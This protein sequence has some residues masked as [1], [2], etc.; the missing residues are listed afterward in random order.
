VVV[1]GIDRATP[2]RAGVDRQ[3]I[4]AFLDAGTQL[5]Q[6]GGQGRDPVRLFVADVGDVA[7]RGRPVREAGHGRECHHGVTD[8]VHVHVDATEPA[9]A[10]DDQTVRAVRNLAAHLFEEFDEPDVALETAARMGRGEAAD[11]DRTAGDGGGGPE[12]AGGGGVRVD[13]VLARA[14]D[15][16][17]GPDGVDFGADRVE[18]DEPVGPHHHLGHA[19]VGFRDAGPLDADRHVALGK[20]GRH[21]QAAEELTAHVGPHADLAAAQPRGADADRRAAVVPLADGIDAE[22]SQ[23]D[24]QVLDGPFPHPGHAVQA[25]LAAPGTDH[26]GEEPHRGPGVG[27]EQVGRAG[28]DEAAGLVGVHRDAG[29]VPV[30]A[31]AEAQLAEAVDHHLGV[32]AAEGP[33]E[34]TRPVVVHAG[35][36][37]Q[38]GQDQGAVRDALAA[39]HGHG[40]RRRSRQRDDF[41]FRRVGEVGHRGYSVRRRGVGDPHEEQPLRGGGGAGE[42]AV[43]GLEHLGDTGLGPRAAADLHQA[44]GD[45]PHHVIEEA[46]GFHVDPDELTEAADAQVGDGADAGEAVGPLGL[47]AAEVVPAD[48]ARPGPAHRFNVKLLP[49]EPGVPAQERVWQPAVLDHI[50]VLLPHGVLVGTE[51][52]RHFDQF[53]HA[54]VLGQLRVDR[55]QQHVGAQFRGG[56]DVRHLADGVDA[57]I[58]PAAAVHPDPLLTG[59]LGDRLLQRLLHGAAAGLRLPAEEVGPVVADRQLQV[60]HGRT[61]PRLTSSSAHCTALLA[62]PLRRLSATSHR[63]RALGLLGSW[64]TRPT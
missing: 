43:P 47:E 29:A 50:A 26:G 44:A 18:S 30:G 14:L 64:R 63:H 33:D 45:R 61:M 55:L 5:A 62:A 35:A 37:G 23:R 53:A 31:D 36:A 11:R 2:Q 21:H 25:V 15:A 24:Q 51:T 27:D 8:V 12:V 16:R 3:P 52:L 41:Q 39:G 4:V 59:D 32:F 40:R 20:G 6:L 7:D 38:G 22:L 42:A 54:H 46:V 49:H 57:G 48:Q 58:G 60:P 9:A 10:A 28:R 56:V 34:G 13:G 17:A 1:V 19:D